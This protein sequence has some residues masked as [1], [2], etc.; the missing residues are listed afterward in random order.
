MAAAE[1]LHPR[2]PEAVPDALE[3]LRGPIKADESF[4]DS[5]CVHQMDSTIGVDRSDVSRPQLEHDR[6]GGSRCLQSGVDLTER[7]ETV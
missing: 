4:I 6:L 1:S 2:V 3:G 7:R 5:I